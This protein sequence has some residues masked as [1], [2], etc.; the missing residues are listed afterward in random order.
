M[1][2][3][4]L[5]SRV[6]CRGKPPRLFESASKNTRAKAVL[7]GKPLIEGIAAGESWGWVLE[8]VRN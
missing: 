8:V 1:A 7:L 2:L 4:L 5:I 6:K 3:D